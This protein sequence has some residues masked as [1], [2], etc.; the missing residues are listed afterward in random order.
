MSPKVKENYDKAIEILKR[1]SDFDKIDKKEIYVWAIS[2][3]IFNGRPKPSETLMKGIEGSNLL[4]ELL[5]L[6]QIEFKN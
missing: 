6:P 1:R 4:A 5:G 2:F 3:T